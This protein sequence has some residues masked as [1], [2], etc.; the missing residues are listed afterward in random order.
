MLRVKKKPIKEC[1]AANFWEIT[2]MPLNTAVIIAYL[3]LEN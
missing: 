2:A 1:A 3:G